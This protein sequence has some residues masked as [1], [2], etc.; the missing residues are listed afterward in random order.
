MRRLKEAEAGSI[1]C[2]IRLQV[3]TQ[4]SKTK[5]VASYLWVRSKGVAKESVIKKSVTK[6]SIAMESIIEDSFTKAPPILC[7]LLKP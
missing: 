5:L 6:E 3:R 7:G 2:V 1:A 4:V